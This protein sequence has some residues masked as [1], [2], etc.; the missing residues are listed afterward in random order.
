MTSPIKAATVRKSFGAYMEP[1]FIV[2]VNQ[3]AADIM[4][5]NKLRYVFAS[6]SAAEKFATVLQSNLDAAY[7]DACGE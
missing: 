4:G 6:L 2:T 3:D 5:E 1:R 7:A